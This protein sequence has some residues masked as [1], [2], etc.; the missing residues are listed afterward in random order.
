MIN[1]PLAKCLD[2]IGQAISDCNYGIDD[3]IIRDPITGDCT[4]FEIGV[5]VLGVKVDD[6]ELSYNNLKSCY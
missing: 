1:E 4:C 5:K 2:I 3:S 6:S